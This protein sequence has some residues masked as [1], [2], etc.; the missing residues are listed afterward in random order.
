[1]LFFFSILKGHLNFISELHDSELFTHFFLE[2]CALTPRNTFT[3]RIYR[4][5]NMPVLEAQKS[6]NNK[7]VKL[8]PFLLFYC[9]AGEKNIL[10]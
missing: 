7:L 5:L 4:I 2:R 3:T 9:I 8:F 6:L 1:M 10:D